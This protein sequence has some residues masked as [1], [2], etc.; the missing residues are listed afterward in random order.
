MAFQDVLTVLRL[1]W[2]VA[3]A[4]LLVTAVAGWTVSHAKPVYQATALVALLPPIGPDQPNSLA[5]VT[6]SVASTGLAVDDFL[7]S[8]REVAV[9]RGLGVRDGFTVAPRN[10]GTDETPAYTIPS[11]QITVLSADPQIAR[12]EAET[13]VGAFNAQLSSLQSAAKVPVKTRITGASLAL[14]AVV[15]LRGARDRGLAGVGLLGLGVAI[16]L[17][18]WVERRR[19]GMRR[20]ALAA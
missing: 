12:N 14:P 4:V 5:S 15:E 3:V 18:I 13:L 16:G 6:P 19:F 11:E 9:L 7:Q 1:R 20:P 10:S 8:A 17:P 2:Y